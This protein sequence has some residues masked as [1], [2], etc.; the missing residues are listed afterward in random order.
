MNVSRYLIS[1]QLY[2]IYPFT[3]KVE[4]KPTQHTTP[5]VPDFSPETSAH[6]YGFGMIWKRIL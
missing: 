1:Q 3:L 4:Q 6:F 5:Q 2:N